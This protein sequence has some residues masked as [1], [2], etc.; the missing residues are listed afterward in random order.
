MNYQVNEN[1][2]LVNNL[3][4]YALFALSVLWKLFSCL[5]HNCPPSIPD[6]FHGSHGVRLEFWQFWKSRNSK[7]FKTTVFGTSVPKDTGRK[8]NVYKT[9]RRRPGRLLNILCTFSLRP[10]PTGVN[11]HL[12]FF[13]ITSCTLKSTESTESTNV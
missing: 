3:I 5:L 8:L 6:I 9:F 13:F 4:I 11:F 12:W 2:L 10:V 1:A 7:A